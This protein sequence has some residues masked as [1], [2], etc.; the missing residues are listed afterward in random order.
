VPYTRLAEDVLRRVVE[1]FVTRDGTDYG[2]AE[3]T[4][5]QK[6]AD[7]RRRLEHGEAAIVYDA[8]SATIN[9]VERRLLR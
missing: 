6:A 5:A 7:V 3:K 1:E 9:V 2:G 8:E 4:L